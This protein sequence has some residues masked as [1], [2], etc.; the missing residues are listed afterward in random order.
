MGSG[1]PIEDKVLGRAASALGLKDGGELGKLNRKA[2]AGFTQK[3]LFECAKRLD[4]KGV[5]KLSKSEL[6][7][8]VAS[9]VAARGAPP[10]VEDR[11]GKAKPAVKPAAEAAEPTV[12]GDGTASAWSHRFEVRE[13]GKVEAP[14]TIPWSYGYNRVTGMAVDPDRLFV[15]WEVTDDAIERAR[16]DLG[17]AGK[18]AWLNLRVYDTTDRIFDGTNAHSYF[19]HRVERSDRHWFFQIG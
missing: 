18:D 2:L 9:E 19:D 15:Y 14:T 13:P 3:Q 11:A 6:A 16:K 1:K 5:A 7:D 17:K 8:R 10:S 12:P 4:L